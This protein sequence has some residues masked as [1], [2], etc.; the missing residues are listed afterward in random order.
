MS[1]FPF[2]LSPRA[3]SMISSTIASSKKQEKSSVASPKESNSWRKRSPFTFQPQPPAEDPHPLPTV[4]PS[5]RLSLSLKA[6]QEASQNSINRLG[7]LQNQVNNVTDSMT[8][9]FQTLSNRFESME[10]QRDHARD[11][12]RK[13][14][15]LF[16]RQLQI[17][18]IILL[19]TVI[20]FVVLITKGQLLF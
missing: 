16:R 2:R 7:Q 14:E 17:D 15:H 19:L 12:T 4:L 9:R 8:L 5:P 1:T 3:M 18:C 13:T 6:L 10:E 20:T 11:L